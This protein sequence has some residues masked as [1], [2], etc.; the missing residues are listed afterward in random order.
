MVDPAALD[1]VLISHL[2]PDHFID[3]VP[4]R[5]YL[6]YELEPPGRVRVAGPGALGARLDALLDEPGFAATSLDL[7][8]LDAV[9][10]TFVGHLRIET[11]SVTHGGDARAIRISR[12]MQDPAAGASPVAGLVYS[13]D[14]GRAEDLDD[15]IRPGDTLLVEISFG[16]DPTPSDAFHLDAASVGMLAT[17]TS[18]GRV[19]LVHLLDGHDPDAAIAAVRA[20]FSGPVTI[21][22][23]GSNVAI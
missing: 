13:G 11:A 20:A 14:C 19:I 6:R 8:L 1:A 23:P 5:H 12:E 4:L 15:L 3:L 7:E 18:A 10:G 9:A 16:A 21:A 17:R 2:H 22:T